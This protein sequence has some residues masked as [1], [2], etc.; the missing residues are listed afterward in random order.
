LSIY[1]DAMGWIYYP[2]K[3]KNKL[4]NFY[5]K[6]SGYRLRILSYH[7]MP[8]IEEPL[9]IRQLK[10]LQ[11]SW[12]IISP[13]E[14]E[15]IM[16]G[17]RLL[18]RDSLLLTFDD[19]TISNFN[20]AEKILNSFNIKALF[21]IVTNYALI[22]DNQKWKGFINKN[23]ML[24]K[25]QN[26]IPKYLRNMSIEN[27]K[28]LIIA[29]H[30]I[31]S[32][33]K[34]HARLSSLKGQEL[35]GEIIE[36]ANMLEQKLMVPINHFA[37]PFGNFESISKEASLIACKRFKYVYTGMR[38]DNGLANE[39]SNIWRD[40]NEP[41]DSLWY[42]SACLEGG[43]DFLYRKKRQDCE[44]WGGKRFFLKKK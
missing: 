31:G 40:S 33:T 35:V 43:A 17:E 13:N 30:T 24:N 41:H 7:D 12:Q 28:S 8:E 18:N 37:Y 38:G 2:L 25:Y 9:F 1:R 14:F 44:K 10:W 19:G 42:T 39:G 11:K 6:K 16:N 23:I 3:F 34:N 22:N 5:Y 26:K 20:V 36:G 29:G 15:L 27:L 21:F 32:H 4:S